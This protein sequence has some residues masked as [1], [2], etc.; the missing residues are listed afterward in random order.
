MSILREIL[1]GKTVTLLSIQED[2]IKKN[3]T[4]QEQLS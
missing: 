4:F 2:E 3:R 1:E